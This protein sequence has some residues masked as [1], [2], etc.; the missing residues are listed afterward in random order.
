MCDLHSLH[1]ALRKCLILLYT[2]VEVISARE[3]TLCQLLGVRNEINS[4][5]SFPAHQKTLC[6][7]SV[8]EFVSI[9]K[10]KRFRFILIKSCGKEK[11]TCREK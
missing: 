1:L 11:L 3:L 2:L 7:L 4:L 9:K 10:M 8:T 6:L 5:I